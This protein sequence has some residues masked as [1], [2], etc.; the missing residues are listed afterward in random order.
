M[1]VADRSMGLG[2]RALNRFAG[3]DV[4][5]RLGV[6][7]PAERVALPRHAATASGPRARA[8]RDVLRRAR[9]LGRP[10]RPRPPAARR[11]CSTSRPTDEQQ[12]LRGGVARLRGRAAA[13][14]AAG[15]RAACEAPRRA[16]RRGRRA[17]ADDARRAR[18][19]GR[20]D[21][22]ALRGDRGA[23]RRGAGPRRRGPGRR[24]RSRP[25]ASRPRWRCGATPTSRRPTCRAF[26]G[27]D[28][29][30]R[31]SRSLEPR[32]AVRP[33]RRW[34]PS[35][36]PQAGGYVLDGVKA[37]V[38][39]AADAELLLVAARLEDGGPALFLVEP[40]PAASS[41]RPSPAM[42]L[43]GAAHRPP[44]ARGRRGPARRA[45][46][47]RRPGGL[48][49][50][51]RP[52]RGWPGARSPSAPARPSSTTSIP[53]VNERMAFGEPISHRQA[54]AFAVSDIAIEL[55]GMRLATLRAAARA[56][57]GQDFAREAALARR[58]CATQ[59]HADRLR[60]RAAARRP[61]LHQGAPRR[62]L[63]PR[64][65]RHRR[66]GRRPGRLM[67][68]PRDPQEVRPADRPGAPGRRRGPPA[69]L[70]Q[71]RPRGARR[72]PR[73]STCSPR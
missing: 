55:E 22:R 16:A 8:G 19:A 2:L 11:A 69:D 15:R 66:H 34:R 5:D 47:R 38:P 42:G 52:R 30:P 48:R 10:A 61:R 27:D 13:P 23:G 28:V 29:P 9:S 20:R 53:Y 51:R 3:S 46:R 59:R 49:R 60:G 41:S 64:P 31:R 24:R 70:A 12:M 68:Q 33:V 14:A 26:V 1:T 50:V 63:V 67:H 7:K 32:A 37:L 57:A 58:L 40:A 72:T 6:R 21:Q 73:S 56:D 25:P 62:A 35:R 54:V 36:A 17:R 45:A 4:V 18:G 44:A 71:V 65:A 39:R 43:R